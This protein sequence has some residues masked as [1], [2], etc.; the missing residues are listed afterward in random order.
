MEKSLALYSPVA[1]EIQ[2]ERFTDQMISAVNQHSC[3]VH[4]Q[5]QL[6][7]M[8]A[9]HTRKEAALYHQISKAQREA[10]NQAFQ[11]KVYGSVAL[12]AASV[13]LI[14]VPP[15]A[16]AC[17]ISAVGLAGAWFHEWAQCRKRRR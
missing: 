16:V 5:K 8:D 6:R 9:R 12:A 4:H 2:Q 10:K 17:L 7:R 3:N 14:P 13:L 11:R 15:V 1:A